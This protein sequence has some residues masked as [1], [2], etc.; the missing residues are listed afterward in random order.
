MEQFTEWDTSSQTFTFELTDDID[1]GLYFCEV[2]LDDSQI[3]TSYQLSVYI[4]EPED[5]QDE[6]QDSTEKEEE[7]ERDQSEDET[8]ENENQNDSDE[9][10][11]SAQSSNSTQSLDNI[12]E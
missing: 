11:G 3:I 5:Q 8:D 6:N 4:S 12:E 9:N 1:A 7:T 10:E 2:T